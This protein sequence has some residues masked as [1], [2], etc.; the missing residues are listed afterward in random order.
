MI[1]PLGDPGQVRVGAK[2]FQA[3]AARM[4]QLGLELRRHSAASSEVWLGWASF[5]FQETLGWGENQ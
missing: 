1:R 4:E 2:W 5:R 3:A